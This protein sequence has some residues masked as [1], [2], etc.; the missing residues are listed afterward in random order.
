MRISICLFDA[1][2]LPD[3]YIANMIVHENNE[4]EE[5]ENLHTKLLN[6]TDITMISIPIE[7]LF[8]DSSFVRYI[9]NSD[10]YIRHTSANKMMK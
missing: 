5:E 6:S 8:V 1:K 3:D 10:T 7:I 9:A 2:H 4:E